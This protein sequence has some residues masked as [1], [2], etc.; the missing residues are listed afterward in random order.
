PIT[1][2]VSGSM[3]GDK[4]ET[5]G[6]DINVSLERTP[7]VYE[8]WQN[9]TYEKL[10]NAY[11]AKL[12][13]Y[14]VEQ[15][16]AGMNENSESEKPK[17]NPLFNRITEQREIKRTCI[18]MLARPF[19]I[20]IGK[21]FY[22]TVT[23]CGEENPTE[24]PIVKQNPLYD[25]YSSH[26][27][28]FEQ[29]FDWEIMSYLFYPYYWADQCKWIELFQSKDAADPIF[30]AFLQSGMARIVVPVRIGFEEA[31][32]YFMETG[33]IWNGGGLVLDSESDLYLSIVEEMQEIEGVVEEEWQTTVPTSLTIVQNESALLDEGGLPCCDDIEQPSTIKTSD[34]TIS[35]PEPVKTEIN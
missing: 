33:E 3:S 13:E 24:I 14:N 7:E 12:D 30:Q 29:A 15:E 6:A 32:S 34:V 19:N 20:P 27:K 16:A 5:A 23:P 10:M 28:F 25:K 9:E 26:V 35:I 8:S 22:R 21:N 11:N 4:I 2:K 1:T 31:V 17:S 18:E